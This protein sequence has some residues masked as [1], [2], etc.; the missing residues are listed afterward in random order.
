[1]PTTLPKLGGGSVT[2]E[3]EKALANSLPDESTTISTKQS[4]GEDSGYERELY[5]DE[6][7][8]LWILLGLLSGSWVLGGVLS[9]PSAFAAEGE[10][11]AA[12][13]ALKAEH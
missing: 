12:T 1:M 7:R 9:R 6:R 3:V 11:H 5:D 2:K 4:D 10:H 8:G 13:E